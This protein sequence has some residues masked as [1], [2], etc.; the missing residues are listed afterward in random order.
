MKKKNIKKLK[1]N[2]TAVS[3]IDSNHVSGGFGTLT[4]LT[5][6]SCFCPKTPSQTNT[7][8]TCNILCEITTEC[9]P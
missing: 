5:C 9:L 6:D 7:T 2:K 3:R 4:C 1:L 8:L